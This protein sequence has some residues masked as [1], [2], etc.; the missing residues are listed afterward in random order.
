MKTQT[1]KNMV[2]RSGYILFVMKKLSNVKKKKL[3]LYKPVTL[4]PISEAYEN[5]FVGNLPK[6]IL[7]SNS[8]TLST[9]VS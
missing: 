2:L 7:S 3:S 1:Q 6:N 8:P 4:L 9:Y 5:S